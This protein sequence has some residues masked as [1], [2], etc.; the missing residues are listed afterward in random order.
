[1]T[2]FAKTERTYALVCVEGRDYNEASD[3]LLPDP[4]VWMIALANPLPPWG[5][6]WT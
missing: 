3:D 6:Y 1:M 4:V 2:P 5:R